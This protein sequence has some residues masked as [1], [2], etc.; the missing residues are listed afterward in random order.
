MPE[1][2]TYEVYKV[3]VEELVANRQLRPGWFAIAQVTRNK[4]QLVGPY[5]SKENLMSNIST[6]RLGIKGEPIEV[7]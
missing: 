2:L 1:N 6:K 4:V 3:F 7:K 5:P